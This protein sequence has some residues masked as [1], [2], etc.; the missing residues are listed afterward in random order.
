MKKVLISG[1]YGQDGSYLAEKFFY[2]NFEVFG[3]PNRINSK[4]ANKNRKI[5]NNKKIIIKI[6]KINLTDETI[7][8]KNLRIIN[9]DVIIHL[10]LLIIISR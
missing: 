10:V 1:I 7:L 3:I 6:K 4:N 2:N 5:L 8:Y 9:P